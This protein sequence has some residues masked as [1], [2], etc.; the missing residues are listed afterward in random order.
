MLDVLLLSTYELGRQP[1]G[2]A[3]AA[4]HLRA[5]GCTV[6]TA[7]LSVEPLP[8]D[9]VAAAGLIAFSVPMHTALRLALPV[10]ARV[11]AL[12]PHAHHC[13]FGLYAALNGDFLLCAGADSVLGGEIETPLVQLAIRLTAADAG[14]GTPAD[15][16][17]REAQPAPRPGR[18][19]APT[20]EP[21][22][23]VADAGLS[24]RATTFLG[25]QQYLPPDRDGLPPLAHYAQL[26]INGGHRLVAAVESSRGCAHRCLH[27]PLTPVYGGRLRIIP[28]EVV[29]ADVRQVVTLGAHHLT[30]ADPDFFNAVPHSFAVLRAIRAEFPSLTFDAT[31]KVEH[32]I[33]QQARLPELREL[34]CAFLLSAVESLSDTVLAALDKGHTAADVATAVALTRRAGIP[35]RPTLLP[36]TP[37]TTL[38]D[39]LA[40][41]AFIDAHDLVDHVDPVQYA[42]RLLVPP[43]SSLLAGAA[44]QPHLGPLNEGELAYRWRHPDP[45]MDDLARDVA[46]IVE[47]GVRCRHEHRDTFAAIA[48]RTGELAGRAMTVR[49]RA[50][51]APPPRLTESWFC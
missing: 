28:V 6:R 25:R 29:L 8:E 4:A 51:V 11:R 10:A 9:A 1:L 38:D 13:F 43:G 32:L 5:A 31:I 3:T 14:T 41:L 17:S 15:R 40:M 35:L 18:A 16:G 50:H 22:R 45:R 39:Y 48:G 34:G 42:I 26:A 36:F 21:P 24:P 19:G 7:D 37:W 20:I 47:T 46:R 2:L 12:N 49:P 23:V 30:F 44:L 27:C 33:E